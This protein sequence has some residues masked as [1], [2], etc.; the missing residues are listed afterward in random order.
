MMSGAPFGVTF[1]D[2]SEGRDFHARILGLLEGRASA[3]H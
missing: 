3:V 2:D 1:E